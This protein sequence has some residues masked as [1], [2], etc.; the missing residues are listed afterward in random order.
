MSGYSYNYSPDPVDP[1]SNFR[2]TYTADLILAPVSDYSLIIKDNKEVISVFNPIYT[3]CK[4]DWNGTNG[5]GGIY[6][7]SGMDTDSNGNLFI[8]NIGGNSVLS[9][10]LAPIDTETI[11]INK[12]QISNIAFD[13]VNN[14]FDK[15]SDTVF[16]EYLSFY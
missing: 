4:G 8:P 15:S 9:L 13:N 14:C 6:S 1:N 10:I 11:V 3:Y 5:N 16:I 7:P 12:N 2:L